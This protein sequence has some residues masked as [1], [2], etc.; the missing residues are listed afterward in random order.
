MVLDALLGAL[1]IELHIKP[2]PAAVERM[3]HRW[4][5]RNEAQVRPPTRLSKEILEKAKPIILSE[6][7][8]KGWQT[9]NRQARRN[10]HANGHA[11]K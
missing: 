8:R 2:D 5:R 3:L 7:A 6:L 10:G 9:R 11:A 4:Q 1:A